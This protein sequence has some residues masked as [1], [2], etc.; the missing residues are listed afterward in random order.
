MKVQVGKI[1]GFISSTICVWW[2]L[3]LKAGC[4]YYYDEKWPALP[5]KIKTEENTTMQILFVEHG[6]QVNFL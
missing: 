1:K 4:Y 5:P 2:P 6:L 3:A